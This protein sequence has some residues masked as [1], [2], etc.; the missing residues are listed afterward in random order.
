MNKQEFEAWLAVTQ[1]SKDRWILDYVT[2]HNRGD[3]L[4]YTGGQSGNYIEI[5]ADGTATIGT[6]EGALP[7]IGEALFQPK[8]TRKFESRDAAFA[9][10]SEALGVQ[11]LI[12][13]VTA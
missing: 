7:H 1:A 9:R 2:Y 4:F 3:L 6:Y 5:A 11:F 12:D 10:V 13:L 8:H